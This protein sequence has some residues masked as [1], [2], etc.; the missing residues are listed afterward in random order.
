MPRPT[1]LGA[2]RD[3]CLSRI[4]L[5]FICLV[6][7][8]PTST[9]LFDRDEVVHLGDHA[10]DRRRVLQ[11]ARPVTPVEA[12]ADQRVFLVLRAADGR[13]GLG[14]AQALAGELLLRGH[15]LLPP[16]LGALGGLR[17]GIALAPADDVADLLAALRRDRAWADHA[18]ERREGRLDHVV[19]VRRADRLGDHVVEPQALEDRAHRAAGDDAGA[20]LRRAQHDLAR[21]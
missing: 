21:A 8:N 19:R 6:L 1:R 10:A 18:A 2:W 4:W 17:R 7:S 3:P 20:R 13:A 14:H 9:D 11:L 12:E 15:R 5:S 16:R